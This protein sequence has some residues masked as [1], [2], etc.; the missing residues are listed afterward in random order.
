MYLEGMD[1]TTTIIR[2][3]DLKEGNRTKPSQ[4]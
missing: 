1:T 2:E 4:K 3:K